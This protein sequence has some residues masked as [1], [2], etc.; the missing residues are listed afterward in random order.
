MVHMEKEWKI[1]TWKHGCSLQAERGA[2]SSTAL[3]S[4]L[5]SYYRYCVFWQPL[6]QVSY[7]LFSYVVCRL[8]TS[9][10]SSLRDL[11]TKI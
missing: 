5:S 4:I 9:N 3:I 10:H 6:P 2:A 1:S 7:D 8:K 11:E